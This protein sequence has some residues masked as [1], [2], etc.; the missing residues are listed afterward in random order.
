MPLL[1]VTL[2][3]CVW[4]SRYHPL[5]FIP[6]WIILLHSSLASHE[7]SSSVCVHPVPTTLLPS[8]LNSLF[9]SLLWTFSKT[10]CLLSLFIDFNT[11]RFF[12]ALSEPPEFWSVLASYLFWYARSSYFCGFTVIHSCWVYDPSQPALIIVTISGL[13]YD[14]QSSLLYHSLHY[15]L[16]LCGPYIALK[17]IFRN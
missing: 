2:G 8:F 4:T 16:S 3:A 6:W 5:M 11:C 1:S 17:I 10:L 12:P 15:L 14:W 13:L 9:W 7:C